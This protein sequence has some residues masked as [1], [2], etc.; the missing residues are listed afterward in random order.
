MSHSSEMNLK[1]HRASGNVW[2][3]SGW[4]GTPQ[5]LTVTRWLIGVGGIALA[6]QGAR[7]RTV[8]GSVLAGLGGSIAWWAL[9]G[10]GDLSAARQWAIGLVTRVTGEAGDAIH[11][12]SDESFPASD[13]PSW[14]AT[15]GT[16]LRRARATT[17]R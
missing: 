7:Q 14:T 10:E 2:A 15:T 3:R 5:Q 1:T 12:A 13:P 6:A 16:G 17:P 11:Q 8:A 9:T 4:N